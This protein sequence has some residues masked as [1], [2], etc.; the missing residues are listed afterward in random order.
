MN[1]IGFVFNNLIQIFN[2]NLEIIKFRMN[3][4]M[5][6]LSMYARYEQERSDNKILF[7]FI[8]K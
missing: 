3:G 8:V 1:V 5:H 2:F 4:R 6:R 7:F